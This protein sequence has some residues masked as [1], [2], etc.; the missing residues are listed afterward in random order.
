[1]AFYIYTE[2]TNSNKEIANLEVNAANM[3]DTIDELQGKI[4]SIS[5]ITNDTDSENNNSSE[6]DENVPQ[7]KDE[8]SGTSS[9]N[10]YSIEK[11][12]TWTPNT[13]S[14]D[15]NTKKW[16]PNDSAEY[17]VATDINNK[18]CIVDSEKNLV[19][20][21]DIVISDLISSAYVAEWE[22]ILTVIQKDQTAY[23]I[24]ITKFTYTQYKYADGK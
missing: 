10:S 13:T 19:K 7:D 17:Y 16:I 14:Y 21:F 12:I 2:K 6:S 9:N 1:M 15:F 23:D 11:I 20:K 22:N 4:D 18:L 24:D 3:Q 8:Q 5:N